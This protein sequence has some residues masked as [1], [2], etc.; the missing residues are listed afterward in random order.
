MKM[1]LFNKR[2]D[3]GETSLLFGGRVPKSDPRT[4]TYGT[5]DEAVSALGLGRALA[6][7]ERVKEIVLDLQKELFVVGA[8]LATREEDMERLTDRVDQ[9]S[10]DRL[11]ELI[12][13]IEGE[14]ELPREFIIPG[15]NP[16]SSALDLARTIIRRGERRAVALREQGILSNPEVLRY[17]NR[18]ADLVFVLA[19]YEERSG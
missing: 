2:G 15:A 16:S 11:Q 18:L 12:E 13:E 9:A 6:A 10:V 8:E 14:I 7:R 19:R 1:K 17:L 4:E 5:L 3:G